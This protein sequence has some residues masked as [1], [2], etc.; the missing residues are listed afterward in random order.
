MESELAYAA[1]E[2]LLV[3]GALLP[4]VNPLGS[5]PIFLGMTSWASIEVRQVLAWRIAVNAFVLMLLSVFF[6]SHI[7]GLFGISLPVVQVAGG[8]LVAAAGWGL[9]QP[10][11][12]KVWAHETTSWSPDE[13]IERAFYPLTFP[14]TVGPGSISVAITLGANTT[15]THM[16]L[17]A[18]T[19][20]LLIATAIIAL[21]VYFCYRFAYKMPQLLGENGTR[22]FLRFSAFILLCIGV[23][24]LWNGINGL[25][26][27]LPH[28]PR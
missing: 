3:V 12:E 6:G 8:L 16:P 27:S 18:F 7:L 9:L 4:I 24:I 20:A 21:S 10:G 11:A 23:Q 2:L 26:M 17:W 1:K 28:V 5:A 19:G 22:I 25:M 13:V 15:R 14:L